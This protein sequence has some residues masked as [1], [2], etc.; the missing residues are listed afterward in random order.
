[1]GYKYIYSRGDYST[2]FT[3][4]EAPG[5]YRVVNFQSTWVIYIM[6]ECNIATYN[7]SERARQAST[8]GWTTTGTK[9]KEL[10]VVV[11]SRSSPN[12]DNDVTITIIE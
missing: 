10:F 8:Y 2:R 9:L 6:I 7:M 11:K 12:F 3:E 4:P 1:M 5:R